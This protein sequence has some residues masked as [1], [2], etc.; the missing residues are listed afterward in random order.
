MQILER[1]D[2][3]SSRTPPGLA[4]M[5]PDEVIGLAVHWPGM[6][7]RT[8]PSARGAVAGLLEGWRRYH[9]DTR[10]WSDIAYPAAIDQE[11]RTWLLRGLHYRS[12]ANGDQRV[13]RLWTAV[14]LIIG[15]D[16]VPSD[17]M[18]DAV[19]RWR[20]EHV[21]HAYPHADRVVGHR[22]LKS[23]DCPGPHV[24]RMVRDGVFTRPP[25]EE[26]EMLPVYHDE[27][28]AADPLRS[29]HLQRW[30][31]AGPARRRVSAQEFHGLQ[32]AGADL[33]LIGLSPRDPFWALPDVTDGRLLP[34]LQVP[35]S[36]APES[37]DRTT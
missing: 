30:V 4:R 9:V 6:T 7:A 1:K 8:A 23:T 22:D 28:A 26:R 35:M 29:P 33:A 18:I 19:R 5:R 12:A 24:Y 2:W 36:A 3:T 20:T 25:K 31:A 10:G 21:L 37:P 13:N 34:T 11:G 14:V 16:E 17:P 32:Y 15:A 27:E